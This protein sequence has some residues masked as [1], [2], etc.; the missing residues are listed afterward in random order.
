MDGYQ[1]RFID[2]I[3]DNVHGFIE[4]TAVEKEIIE[5]PIFKRLQSIKQLGL[6]NWI[7]PGAEHTRFIHSLGVMHL[8]DQM[9]IQL[10]Y[11][12]EERQL[13]RLAGL[14]HDIG[15]YPLSHVGERAY[16]SL[17]ANP[18]DVVR[19]QKQR[20]IDG[21]HSVGD[22][23]LH[24][25]Q[26]PSNPYH[27][28]HITEQVIKS[29]G[30]IRGIIDRHCGGCPLI[31][32]ENICDIIVGNVERNPK[33]SGLVQLVHSE[34]DADRIDYIMRDATFSGTSYGGFELGL[35]LRNL[36]RTDYHGGEII[37][38][39]PKGISIADQFLMNRYYSYTQV[40]FNRHVSILEFMARTL[41]EIFISK[42]TSEYP[43][44]EVLLQYIKKH[45]GKTEFLYFTDRAFWDSVHHV[46]MGYSPYADVFQEL[47][48][49]Y[50]ELDLTENKQISV[51]FSSEE[52]LREHLKEN[53]IC[54]NVYR[55]DAETVPI[56]NI[57]SFTH[58][59]PSAVYEQKLLKLLEEG[60]ISPQ[61]A[62]I[63]RIR[64]LQEGIT[65]IEE[66]KEP[67]LLSDSPASLMSRLYSTKVCI[68]REYALPV[69]M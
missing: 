63:M 24:Y 19:N 54:R 36:A 47:L 23:R 34:L 69:Q 25:M 45:N 11:S 15:H 16:K 7:F 27:H 18:E 51:T 32:I 35:F 21:L 6:T 60:K 44:P 68:L 64:R 33:I 17:P 26:E 3:L 28:E 43:S 12:G 13:V 49:K 20:V 65:I 52:E 9:A 42:N 41:T 40:F 48:L 37:G 53:P 4:F 10:R 29:D 58:Q 1:V 22:T 61:Q 57:E 56:L 2:K 30:D 8:A 39:H 66:G 55:D 46:S 67:I 59:Q 31:T 14:L 38:V 5:L 62:D 50:Q